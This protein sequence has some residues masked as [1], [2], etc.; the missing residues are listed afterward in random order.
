M[1]IC[2][3]LDILYYSNLIR[4]SHPSFYRI[5]YSHPNT[6]YYKGLISSCS[7]H[8]LDSSHQNCGYSV[9]PENVIIRLETSNEVELGS[10]LSKFLGCW[11]RL[12]KTAPWVMDQ[13]FYRNARCLA[14]A[15]VSL[16][17]LLQIYREGEMGIPPYI[18]P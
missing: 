2:C 3:I 4:Q 11:L 1:S 17:V 12:A 6:S 5:Q 14:Y 13:H 8:E 15:P 7:L 9:M 16:S 10:Q 18:R